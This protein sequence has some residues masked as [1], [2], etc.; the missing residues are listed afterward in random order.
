MYHQQS[1]AQTWKRRQRRQRIMVAVIIV[2]LLAALLMAGSTCSGSSEKS[3]VLIG[4]AD[5]NR[6]RL[7]PVNN[8]S[9]LRVPERLEPPQIT[10]PHHRRS[11]M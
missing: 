8:E 10:A 5:A 7:A 11:G 9:G 4:R 3:R 6:A 2:A 1:V